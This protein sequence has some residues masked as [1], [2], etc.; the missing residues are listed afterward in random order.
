MCNDDR[1]CTHRYEIQNT[2]RI[3]FTFILFCTLHVTYF[4][5]PVKASTTP[6]S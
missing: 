3:H 4:H 2:D 1:L 6:K 5:L